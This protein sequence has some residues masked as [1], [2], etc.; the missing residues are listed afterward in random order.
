MTIRYH[1]LFL[2]LQPDAEAAASIGRLMDKLC[3]EHGLSPRPVGSKCLHI[4]L[5]PL[6]EHVDLPVWLID[7]AKAALS[8]VTMPPFVVALNRAVSWKGRA[9]R[10]LLALLGDEGV[11][12]VDMLR[13]QIHAALAE[14]SLKPRR[15][16]ETIPH[17]TLAY[18]KLELPDEIIVDVRWTVREFV[19]VD[20]LVGESHH[21]VLHRWPLIT[22]DPTLSGAPSST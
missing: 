10:Q 22:T 20:S 11:V 2:A 1:N 7:K 8:T 9:G 4:S 18:G 16:E 14:A 13:A 5:I 19:L 15:Y 17:L 6:G 3:R 12:G 21:D